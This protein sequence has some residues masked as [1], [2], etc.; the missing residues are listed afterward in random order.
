MRL[1]YQLIILKDYCMR[2]I[3][4]FILIIT[5]NQISLLAQ[6]GQFK[7][8]EVFRNNDVVF[9]QIDQ[10]TWV[11]TGKLV[12]NESLYLIEGNNKAILIDAGTKIADL[13]KIVTSLTTK[14][15]TLVVT[16]VHPDHTGTAVNCFPEIYL[17]AADIPNVPLFMPD[18]RGTI[19]YLKDGEI[20]D[21]GNRQIEVVFTPGHTPGSTSFIDKDAA[22]GFSGDAFNSYLLLTTNFSTLIASCERM[23]NILK[24]YGIT[25]F[26]T[27][28]YYGGDAGTLQLL[29]NMITLSKA[30]LNGKIEEKA[31]SGGMLG[32]NRSVNAYGITINYSDAQLK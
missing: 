29:N 31:N 1:D 9:R 17:N 14:P 30:V 19:R 22:Y 27:G 21:L 8:K 11:G 24:K 4:F 5:L 10:H 2:K 13:D 26:Y 32:L 25:H 6:E 12:S 15:V 3:V 28:H 7:E 23:A 18:Y 20:F 16:H